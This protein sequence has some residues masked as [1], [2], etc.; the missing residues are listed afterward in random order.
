MNKIIMTPARQVAKVPLLRA[1]Q[2]RQVLLWLVEMTLMG[3]KGRRLD[4][5]RGRNKLV[6]AKEGRNDVLDR[7]KD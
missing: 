4:G 6:V 3:A 5:N 2:Q 1:L 7:T